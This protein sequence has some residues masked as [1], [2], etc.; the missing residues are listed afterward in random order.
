MT[1][2]SLKAL[3]HILASIDLEDVEEEVLT[4]E[5]HQSYCAA[6]FAVFPRIQKDIKKFM[7]EQLMFGATQTG[8]LQQLDFSR[9]TMNGFYL[10]L[11]HWE[12]AA[13]EYE[14]KIK[15]QKE[16]FDKHEV[17]GII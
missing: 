15:Q 1:E 3:R 2:E 14:A 9:G 8:T 13:N 11:E 4:P 10:L 16:P 12:K 7:H 5:E 6:I 17:V